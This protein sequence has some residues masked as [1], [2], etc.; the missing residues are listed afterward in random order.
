MTAFLVSFA[1]VTIPKSQCLFITNSSLLLFGDGGSGLARALAT[2]YSIQL[3]PVG[4]TG[5]HIPENRLKDWL[6]FRHAVLVAQRKEQKPSTQGF[7][8]LLPRGG[9]IC[10]SLTKAESR[11]MFHFKGERRRIHPPVGGAAKALWNWG[12]H[13][14]SQRGPWK[15]H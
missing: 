15:N 13:L 2:I 8:K 6:C 11:A 4:S 1:D 5:L 10:I 7:F 3:L 9:I 14:L 12:E